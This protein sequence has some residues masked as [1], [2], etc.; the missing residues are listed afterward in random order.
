MDETET[1]YLLD[2]IKSVIIMKHLY[3]NL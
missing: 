1:V 2:N 3:L